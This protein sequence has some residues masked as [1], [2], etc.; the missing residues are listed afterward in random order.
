MNV[1]VMRLVVLSPWMC[2][3]LCVSILQLNAPGAPQELGISAQWAW[4]AGHSSA[5][6]SEL[7]NCCC[8][9]VSLSLW[10][11]LSFMWN[12]D[13]TVVCHDFNQD[14]LS[15]LA[16]HSNTSP[17]DFTAC[18]HLFEKSSVF[19]KKV[20]YFPQNYHWGEKNCR[21]TVPLVNHKCIK[22]CSHIGEQLNDSDL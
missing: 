20:Q 5:C 2:L 1:C 15:T 22:D 3:Q 6:F 9:T 19:P 10:G 11:S 18:F 4:F 17:K 16:C 21:W 7:C 8:E 13:S 12:Q 14:L